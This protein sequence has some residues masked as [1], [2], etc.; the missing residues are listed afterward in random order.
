M[1]Y[2]LNFTQLFESYFDIDSFDNWTITYNNNE[3]HNLEERILNRSDLTEDEFKQI[4]E[5]ICSK[6]VELNLMEKLVYFISF[7]HKVKIIV[8]ISNPNMILIIS[9][10]NEQHSLSNEYDEIVYI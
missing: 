5:K 4:I 10:L 1:R 3:S 7:E 9:I 8:K 6:I 2:I